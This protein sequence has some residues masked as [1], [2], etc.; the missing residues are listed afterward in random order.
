MKRLIASLSDPLRSSLSRIRSCAEAFAAKRR[1]EAEDRAAVSLAWADQSLDLLEEWLLDEEQKQILRLNPWD[2]FLLYASA[3]LYVL[4]TVW[5]TDPRKD[6][7]SEDKANSASCDRH[8]HEL[9]LDNWEHLGIPN[10]FIATVIAD[11]CRDAGQDPA[12]P[13]ADAEDLHV[14]DGSVV[15]NVLLSAAIRLAARRC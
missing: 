15:N 8:I 6:A 14:V 2:V 13:D 1:K 4:G 9:I 5:Q 3:Y 10:A 11:I 7:R 12:A